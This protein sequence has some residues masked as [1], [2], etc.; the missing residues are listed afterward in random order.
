MYRGEVRSSTIQGNIGIPA[1]GIPLSHKIEDIGVSASFQFWT[2]SC[3]KIQSPVPGYSCLVLQKDS[4]SPLVCAPDIHS[5][6]V[7]NFFCLSAS[8]SFSSCSINCNLSCWYCWI[9]SKFSWLSCWYWLKW[10]RAAWFS[11]NS[12]W[13][14]K[15]SRMCLNRVAKSFHAE[16]KTWRQTAR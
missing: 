10:S 1:P 13:R 5:I 15:A 6:T 8:S 16:R 2:F 3:F 12:L 9:W 7:V 11:I 14:P 4:W